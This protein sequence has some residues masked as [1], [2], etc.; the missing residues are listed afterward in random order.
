MQHFT[1]QSNGE[2]TT[3]I[4]PVFVQQ[5]LA[6]IP[7][8]Y[9]RTTIYVK[10]CLYSHEAVTSLVIVCDMSCCAQISCHMML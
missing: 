8:S 9:S 7:F 1:A 10:T 3:E 5:I 4:F 2:P 6:L